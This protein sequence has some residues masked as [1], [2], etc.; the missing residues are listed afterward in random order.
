MKRLCDRAESGGEIIAANQM[1]K[2]S[3]L[4]LYFSQHVLSLPKKQKNGKL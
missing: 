1:T 4:V 3:K 2:T